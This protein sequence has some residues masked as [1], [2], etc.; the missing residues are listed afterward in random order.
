MATLLGKPKGNGKQ[1]DACSVVRTA[2]NMSFFPVLVCV[3]MCVVVSD[4]E[5]RETS[6]GP[7]PHIP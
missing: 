6:L 5:S 2:D 4:A 7:D 1:A 3:P